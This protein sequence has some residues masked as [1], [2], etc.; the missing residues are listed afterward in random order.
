MKVQVWRERQSFGAA[1]A[2][3]IVD[4]LD[5]DDNILEQSTALWSIELDNWLVD[6]GAC[7]ISLPAE[8]LR[9]SLRLKHGFG[10]L[11]RDWGD[12]YFNAVLYQATKSGF[13][14]DAGVRAVLSS[15]APY[16]ANPSDQLGRKLDDVDAVLRARGA[17]LTQWLNYDAPTANTILGAAVATYLSDRFH[18]GDRHRLFGARAASITPKKIAALALANVLERVAIA[19]GGRPSSYFYSAQQNIEAGDDMSVDVEWPVVVKEI[20]SVLPGGF[21]ST[22]R[23]DEIQGALERKLAAH[24][25][26]VVDAACDLLADTIGGDVDTY[27]QL[28]GRTTTASGAA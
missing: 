27:R 26:N 25:P 20:G 12:G 19:N 16:R 24:D 13:S 10:A 9:F 18:V 22:E 6:Q 17:E 4:F 7:A 21:V 15:I 1:P 5:G 14:D 3:L 2:T 8:A 11:W 28:W 23:K